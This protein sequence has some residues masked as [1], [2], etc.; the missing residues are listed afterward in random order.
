MANHHQDA[1]GAGLALPAASAP[2][3]CAHQDEAPRLAGGGGHAEQ[4][5]ADAADC[6]DAPRAD[7]SEAKHFATL[8]TQLALKGWTLSRSANGAVFHVIRWGM[9]RE[10]SDLAAVEAFADQVGAKP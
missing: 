1:H 2:L 6:A 4:Q 9:V 5:K 10:L 3:I 7:Q 8:Q